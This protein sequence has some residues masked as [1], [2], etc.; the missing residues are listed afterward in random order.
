MAK[1]KH[2][3]TKK[4]TWLLLAALILPVVPFMAVDTLVMTVVFLGLLV[5]GELKN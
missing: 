3:L 2:L 5:W 1:K 4:Q